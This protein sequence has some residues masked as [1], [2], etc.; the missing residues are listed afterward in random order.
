M[1]PRSSHALTPLPQCE[2]ALA[3]VLKEGGTPSSR[4]VDCIATCKVRAVEDSIEMTHRLKQEVGSFALMA[5]AGFMHLDFLQCCKFAEG[6]SRI[7]MSK[8]ARD[9]LRLVEKG[10][11]RS[12]PGRPMKEYSI[13]HQAISSLPPSVAFSPSQS[14]GPEEEQVMAVEL[15]MKMK[16]HVDAG[17]NKQ[18]AWDKEWRGVY[19]LAEKVMQRVM[20]EGPL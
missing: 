5:D 16:G 6:D 17:C 8:I 4:L 20:E 1:S 14:A 10:K 19:D 7:L 2:A 12:T 3:K 9:R 11:V 15:A 13:S 18:E